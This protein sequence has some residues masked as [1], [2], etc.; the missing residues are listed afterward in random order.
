VQVSALLKG[1]RKALGTHEYSSALLQC[2]SALVLTEQ[3]A[4]KRAS[5]A[6]FKVKAKVLNFGVRA[7][8]QH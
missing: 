3:I 1:A 2:E 5:R 4:D 7:Q 6:V 8:P